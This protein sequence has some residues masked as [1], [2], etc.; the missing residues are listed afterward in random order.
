MYSPRQRDLRE[1]RV[2]Q[3][4]DEEHASVEAVTLDSDDGQELESP[5]WDMHLSTRAS[6]A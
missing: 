5:P 2:H 1:R 6:A 3:R 4:F